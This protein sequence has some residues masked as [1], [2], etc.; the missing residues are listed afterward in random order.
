MLAIIIRRD[1][2]ARSDEIFVDQ[3]MPQ[4]LAGSRERDTDEKAAVFAME[5]WKFGA[6]KRANTAMFLMI[7]S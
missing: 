2:L 3:N 6:K 1:H 7:A 5:D 4:P